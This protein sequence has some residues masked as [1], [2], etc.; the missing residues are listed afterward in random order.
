[1]NDEGERTMSRSEG[2]DQAPPDSAC[3]P[4]HTRSPSSDRAARRRARRRLR[5]LVA[6]LVGAGALGAALWWSDRLNRRD[7][8]PPRLPS[9]PAEIGPPANE[10]ADARAQADALLRQAPAYAPFFA[11]LARAFPADAAHLRESFAARVVSDRAGATPDR[12]LT[13]ALTAL[14][15]TRGVVAAK[16][17]GPAMTRLFAA[18]AATLDGLKTYD[19]RLC[20]DFLYGGLTDAFLDFAAKNRPLVAELAD[21]GLA[22]VIDGGVEK[23]EREAPVDADFAALEQGL[24]AAGLGEAEINALLDGK[25]PDPPLPDERMCDAGRAYQRALD[26]LPEP[27]RG[28]VEALAIELMSRS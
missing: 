25:A 20:V 16:A 23:I 15:R 26:A 4:T 7:D 9:G 11:T 10:Q 5:S 28:R 18:Q 17:G 12:F 27:S 19:P 8:P 22:A 14:R 13:E 3:A 21:A 6:A 1:M 24:R 2:G